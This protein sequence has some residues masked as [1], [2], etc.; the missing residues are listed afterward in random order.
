MRVSACLSKHHPTQ[1]HP[2]RVQ[3]QQDRR[4]T[5]YIYITGVA[6]FPLPYSCVIS[7]RSYK[8]GG[9]ITTI[10]TSSLVHV[11]CHQIQPTPQT[12]QSK[13]SYTLLLPTTI[14]A[15]KNTPV[16]NVRITLRLIP[17][18]TNNRAPITNNSFVLVATQRL[19]AT[20]PVH[21]E[22]RG[23]STH[24]LYIH[25]YTYT[26]CRILCI[27]HAFIHMYTCMEKYKV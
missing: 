19:T 24:L 9:V 10:P 2:A 7:P 5:L 4:N 26:V 17:P 22:H 20:S 25:H 18:I 3:L 21:E 16:L 13:L 15:P 14:Y 1:P 8:Y 12:N 6:S 23:A 11:D 27:A